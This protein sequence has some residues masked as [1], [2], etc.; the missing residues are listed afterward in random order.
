MSKKHFEA[1]DHKENAYFHKRVGDMLTE[2]EVEELV[3]TLQVTIIPK[4]K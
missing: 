2:Q 4:N 1:I 3:V